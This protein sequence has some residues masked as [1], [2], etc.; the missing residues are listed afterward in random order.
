MWLV[1]DLLTGSRAQNR[2]YV[3]LKFYFPEAFSFSHT[4]EIAQDLSLDLSLASPM[5]LNKLCIPFYLELFIHSWRATSIH[6]ADLTKFL[7]MEF[8]YDSMLYKVAN[9]WPVYKQPLLICCNLWALT[10]SVS[11]SWLSKS[12]TWDFFANNRFVFIIR[13]D[14]FQVGTELATGR[15]FMGILKIPFFLGKEEIGANG[16]AIKSIVEKQMLLRHRW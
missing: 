4:V 15:A 6:T 1:S 13:D 14:C 7:W 3:T 2:V 9:Y 12:N 10:L 11:P 8:A 16:T 5:A